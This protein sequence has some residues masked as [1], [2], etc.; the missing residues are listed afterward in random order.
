MLLSPLL[1][2]SPPPRCLFNSS[3]YNTDTYVIK[4]ANMFGVSFFLSL[5]E[6]ACGQ[7]KAATA[8]LEGLFVEARLECAQERQHSEVR[9]E[10][11]RLDAQQ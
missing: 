4:Q 7:K 1:S 10:E 6:M 3:D 2:R 11:T 5:G 8:A 9:R